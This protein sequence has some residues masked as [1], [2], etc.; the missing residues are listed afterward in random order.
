MASHHEKICI[1]S[2]GVS[3]RGF[4]HSVTAGAVAAGTLNLRDLMS[5]QAAELQKQGRSMIL[6]WMNGAP[7]QFESF[8][9]KPDNADVTGETK[10]IDTNVPGIQIAHHWNNVAKV[11]NEIA[12]IRSLTNKEGQHQ[13]DIPDAHRLYPVEQRQVPVA[14]LQH[15]ENAGRSGA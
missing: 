11:M 12:L 13:R 15:R 3:R 2:R 5:L 8:D 6:L 1:T 14:R 7:S 10:A 4:L 9:P